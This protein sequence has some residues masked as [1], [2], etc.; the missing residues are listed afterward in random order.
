MKQRESFVGGAMALLVSGIVVKLL[1]ALFKVPLTNLIGDSGMGLF[2]FAMQFFSL[3]FVVCAAGLPVAE[4]HLVSEA[5]ALGDRR[6]AQAVVVHAAAV[7]GALALA[8]SVLLATFAPMICR[9]F[10]E[11][12]NTAYCLAA[13]APAVFF[14]TLEAALR[15]W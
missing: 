4:S 14:V 11:S 5:L 12:I 3:L 8:M 9:L 6:R 15:G 10:G 7:F 2:S 1:G 13:I